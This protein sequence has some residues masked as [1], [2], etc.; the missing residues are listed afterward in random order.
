MAVDM[1]MATVAETG[2]MVA[3]ITN[4]FLHIVA[5]TTG[6]GNTEK[7]SIEI[8][9]VMKIMTEVTEVTM[10]I[11]DLVVVAGKRPNIDSKIGINKE[12]T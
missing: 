3:V 9:E 7:I 1:L 4:R 6:G 12:A 5:T 11:T 2:I 10:A 8:T